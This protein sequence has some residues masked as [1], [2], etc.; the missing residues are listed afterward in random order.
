MPIILSP[1][2]GTIDQRRGQVVVVLPGDG[3]NPPEDVLSIVF[4]YDEL[5]MRMDSTRW[6]AKPKTFNLVQYGAI[7]GDAT[8]RIVIHDHLCTGH[9]R[10]ARYKNILASEKHNK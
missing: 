3:A 5:T 2:H 10:V 9:V 1:Q 7:S 8:S 4:H 6:F